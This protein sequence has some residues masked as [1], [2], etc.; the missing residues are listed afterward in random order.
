MGRAQRPGSD[1]PL[2]NPSIN[3]WGIDDDLFR[4]PD[5]PLLRPSRVPRSLFTLT[6]HE[7]YL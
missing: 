1:N 7:K 2:I 5:R 3:P 6:P 4:L